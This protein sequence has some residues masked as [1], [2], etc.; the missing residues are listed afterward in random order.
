MDARYVIAAAMSQRY[1]DLNGHAY[2][3]DND[4]ARL[5]LRELEAHGFN[6]VRGTI[7]DRRVL[8]NVIASAIWAP[9]GSTLFTVSDD[10]LDECYRIA[11][12]ILASGYLSDG[13]AAAPP[14]E[15]PGVGAP[16]AAECAN[17]APPSLTG[18]GP[19]DVIGGQPGPVVPRC[20]ELFRHRDISGVSGTGPVAQG[21]QFTDG[22][23]ALRWPGADPSTAVWP[24]VEAVLKIH[25]HSGAT[26]V[27]WLDELPVP[28][29][30]APT[31]EGE[32]R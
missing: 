16:A 5:V 14:A 7:P 15:V 28:Y 11:D 23:V 19:V 32:D 21:V 13:G 31:K 4:G 25:G 20:F 22:S 9:A 29:W 17:A 6:I 10:Q 3:M 27:R 24:S 2:P 30:P 12:E 1:E 8:A 26:E 18:S